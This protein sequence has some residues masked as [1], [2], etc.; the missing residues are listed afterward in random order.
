MYLYT[1]YINIA[2]S[3]ARVYM[4]D[5]DTHSLVCLTLVLYRL[6][7]EPLQE[8]LDSYICHSINP[9]YVIHI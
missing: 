5:D 8:S 2:Y 9:V 6:I 1:C 4:K 7:L 3:R